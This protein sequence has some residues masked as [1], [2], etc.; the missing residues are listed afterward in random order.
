MSPFRDALSV[1]RA[2][3]EDLLVRLDVDAEAD[4]DEAALGVE[5]AEEDADCLADRLGACF[6]DIVVGRQVVCGD[7]SPLR[8]DIRTLLPRSSRLAWALSHT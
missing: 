3:A 5:I 8:P 1:V 6:V 2:L 4:L 7:P